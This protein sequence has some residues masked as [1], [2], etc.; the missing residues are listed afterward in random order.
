[1]A[2][3]RNAEAATVADADIDADDAEADGAETDAESP[4]ANSAAETFAEADM[5]SSPESGEVAGDGQTEAQDA[6][7]SRLDATEPGAE[8]S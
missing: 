2:V 8:T 7:V 5:G 6:D 1:V 3:A 4:A